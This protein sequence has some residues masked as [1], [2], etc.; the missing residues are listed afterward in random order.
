MKRDEARKSLGV[1]TE[2]K[3]NRFGFLPCPFCGGTDIRITQHIGQGTGFL[4]QGEDV[5]SMCCYDCGATFPNR[6]RR[7]LLVECWNRRATPP[8]ATSQAEPQA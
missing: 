1:K 2:A 8:T 7:E 4:H 3:T 5:F 6:Y